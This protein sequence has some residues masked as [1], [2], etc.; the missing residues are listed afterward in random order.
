VFVTGFKA[1]IDIAFDEAGNLYVLQHA[2]GATALMGPGMLIR[3]APD[4]TRTQVL[5]QLQRPTSVAIG[6]DGAV[7][8]S[9]R[10]TSNGAG[11]VLRVEP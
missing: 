7:Y 1:I 8:V 2:T 11:E 4:G 3:V 6:P 9:N 10:G 5:T